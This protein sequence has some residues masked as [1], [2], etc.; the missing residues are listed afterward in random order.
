MKLGSIIRPVDMEIVLV[1]VAY[2]TSRIWIVA[3]HE[4]RYADTLQMA[5]KRKS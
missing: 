2:F 3:G 5:V 4:R 1:V